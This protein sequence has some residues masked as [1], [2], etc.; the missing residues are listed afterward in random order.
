MWSRQWGQW[1]LCH[2]RC[3]RAWL[4]ARGHA[5]LVPGHAQRQAWR[6]SPGLGSLSKG[7]SVLRPPLPALAEAGLAGSLPMGRILGAARRAEPLPSRRAAAPGSILLG[8][9]GAQ[10]AAP[11]PGLAQEPPMGP[12]PG[13]GSG[14]GPG[15]GPGKAPSRVQ[16]WLE[17]EGRRR[18]LR[19][20]QADGTLDPVAMET[21]LLSQMLLT[22]K[23]TQDG[24]SP[25]I[26]IRHSGF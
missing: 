25:K 13:K 6:L 2:R 19:A 26:T 10:I 17:G 18:R 11:C 21:A 12:G 4:K 15:K 5:E 1:R 7:I 23:S 16:R 8:C 3:H 24:I 14:K 20:P 9:S 22:L